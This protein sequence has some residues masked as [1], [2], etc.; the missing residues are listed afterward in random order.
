MVG[1]TIGTKLILPGHEV[2]M[3]SR[4]ANNPKAAEW[5]KVSGA[6]ASCGTFSETASFGEML[7][8]CTSGTGSIAALKSA[9][10][11]NLSGKILVDVANPLDFSRGMPPALSVCNTDSLGE[12]IQ[13]TFPNA[14]V[15]K[16]LNTVNCNLMVNPSLLRGDHDLFICGND[17]GAKSKVTQI[18][19]EWF[20]WRSVINIGDITGAR[21][22]K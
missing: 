1:S 15:V 7:F 19:K 6:K 9:G 16:T 21:L 2:K 22:R 14:K 3:G 20:G 4:T 12:Q 13:R 8:N 17:S 18:L 10:E 11:E 5:A